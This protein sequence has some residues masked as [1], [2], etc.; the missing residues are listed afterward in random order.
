MRTD[1]KC[2]LAR[3]LLIRHGEAA[4]APWPHAG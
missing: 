3:K 4:G 2:A 1:A